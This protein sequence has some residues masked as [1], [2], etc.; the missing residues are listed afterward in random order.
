MNRLIRTQM[1]RANFEGL[2]ASHDQPDLLRLFVLKETNIAGP[3]F[4]PFAGDGVESEQFGAPGVV[5]R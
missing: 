2:V 1:V 3:S 4:F 5:V